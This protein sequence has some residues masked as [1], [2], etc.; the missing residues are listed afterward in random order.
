MEAASGARVVIVV[1]TYDEATNVAAL[2]ERVFAAV[3]DA[4]MV[5]VD[6]GSPDGTADVVA[7]LQE[8]EPRLHLV[9]RHEK[10][11]LGESLIAGMR[12]ALDRGAGVVVTMDGD[13]SHDPASLPSLLEAARTHDLVVGSRYVP[14]GT[15]P[16]WNVF[17]RALSRG[18]NSYQEL[19]LR[20]GISDATSGYR[21]YSAR[22]LDRLD[23]SQ[24]HLEGFGFQ[25]EMVRRAKIAG[26]T[27][28]EVP[29]SFT[30]REMG[31]SKIDRRTIFEAFWNV[32]RWGVA[33]LLGRDR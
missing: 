33:R 29:I 7:G 1:P 15:I 13:L 16:R 22:I 6:D 10:R 4:E 17:R 3:P 8:D 23:L 20:L 5:V 21:A 26:A 27:V 18:G 28:T 24:A 11:G 32:T 31:E 2:S 19:M 30:E 25:I 12:W 14:G 9:R